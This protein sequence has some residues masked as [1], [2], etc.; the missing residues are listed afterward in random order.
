MVTQR[1]CSVLN[2]VI[3]NL[4]NYNFP[5]TNYYEGRGALHDGKVPRFNYLI[6]PMMSLAHTYQHLE[7]P[8]TCSNPVLLDSSYSL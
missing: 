5:N 7:T 1:I 6:L 3:H 4:C 8:Q 2:G